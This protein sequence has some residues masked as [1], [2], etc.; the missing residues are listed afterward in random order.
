MA[1]ITQNPFLFSTKLSQSRGFLHSFH[2]RVSFSSSFLSVRCFSAVSQKPLRLVNKPYINWFFLLFFFSWLNVLF[3]IGF[4]FRY[5]VL[6]AGFAGLSVVWH[7][8]QVSPI[9]YFVFTYS[10]CLWSS[11]CTLLGDNKVNNF[12]INPKVKRLLSYNARQGRNQV[13]PKELS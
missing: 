3:G 12:C 8:L 10:Y 5:A 11:S 9:P 2:K 1:L 4:I 7:L 13:A 6:G